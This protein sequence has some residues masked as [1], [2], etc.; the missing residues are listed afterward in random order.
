MLDK[1]W[2]TR[3]HQISCKIQQKEPPPK[4]SICYVWCKEQTAGLPEVCDRL[5]AGD[6]ASAERLLWRGEGCVAADGG[7][8]ERDDTEIK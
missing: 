4:Q 1:K 7:A 6:A 2:A 5:T 3:K 8:F